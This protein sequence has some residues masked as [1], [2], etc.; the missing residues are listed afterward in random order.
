MYP[1]EVHIFAAWFWGGYTVNNP[2]LHRFYSIHFTL[3]FLIAGVSLIHL[4]LLHKDGSNS[5][6]SSDTGVDDIPFLSIFFC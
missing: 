1:I 3:P 5:P 4:T 2:T 6:I